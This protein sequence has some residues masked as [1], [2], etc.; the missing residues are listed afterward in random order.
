[1]KSTMSK[2]SKAL[3]WRL[4]FTFEIKRKG[5]LRFQLNLMLHL[6]ISHA[7]IKSKQAENIKS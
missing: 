3:A 4:G 6:S 1:M 7:K 5:N 2:Q